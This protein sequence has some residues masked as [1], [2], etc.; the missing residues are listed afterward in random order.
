M[1]LV[2]TGVALFGVSYLPF[3][4]VKVKIDSYS[5]SGTADN[6]TI[7]LFK[8]IAFNLRIIAIVTIIAGGLLYTG[9]KRSLQYISNIFTSLISFLDELTRHFKEAV[10]KEDKIHLYALFI[11]MLAAIAARLIFLFSIPMTADEAVTFYA[12]ALKPLFVGLTNYSA[13]NNHLFHTFLVHIS[14]LLFGSPV[15]AIRLPAFLAGILLVP[16]SYIVIRI[17]YNK[18]AALLTAGFAASSMVLIEYSTLARG[19]TLICLFFLSILA[20]ATYLKQSRNPAAWLLFAILS[21]LGFYTIPIMLYPFG[22]VVTW[23]FLSIMSEKT[24]IRRSRLLT[25]LFVY[26]IVTSVL[27]LILYAPVFA[28]SG[29]KPI[30]ANPWVT[31]KPWSYFITEFP[32]SLRSLW[33]EWNTDIPSVISLFMATGFFISLVFH[34]RLS[35]YRVPIIV[36]AVI[37]C[38]PV[39]IAQ[40][41]TPYT[42]VW[43]FL[44]PVYIGYASAGVIFLLSRVKFRKSHYHTVIYSILA[45]TLSVW[46][47]LNVKLPYYLDKVID[48]EPIA[49]FLKDYIKPGDRVLDFAGNEDPDPAMIYYFKLHDVP[50]KYLISDIDS[51]KRMLVILNEKKDTLK[52]LL[53]NQGI[54][55]TKYTAPKLIQRYNVMS[56]YEMVR[57]NDREERDNRSDSVE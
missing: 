9:R 38:I 46:L 25:D 50:V 18:H 40:R 6:F 35:V 22:I 15:W 37:W 31:S 52:D 23:L 13:P 36:A 41:V 30:V 45:V 56:L 10:K 11:I 42:R 49:L 55:L 33:E 20:L 29:I 48:N 2:T 19:Y 4:L 44:L 54:L 8:E 53:D 12:Y 39:L 27:T 16:A 1:L 21:A 34:K 3:E 26:L 28:I 17:F 14:Y 47:S 43:L 32:L 57:L 7:G 5:L 51:S 24:A